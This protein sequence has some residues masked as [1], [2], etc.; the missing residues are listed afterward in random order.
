MSKNSLAWLLLIILALIWGCSFILIKEALIIFAPDELGAMRIAFTSIFLLLVGFKKLKDIRLQKAHLYI[1]AGL[2]GNLIPSFLF[3]FAQTRLESS[4]AGVLN[5][6]SPLFS[7]LIGWGIFKQKMLKLQALGIFLS[8]IGATCLSVAASGGLGSFNVYALLVVLATFCYGMNI[9]F[10]KHKIKS[11]D[12]I[13]VSVASILLVSPLAWCYLL[14]TDVWQQM[15]GSPQLLVSL[16]A[17]VLLAVF[18]SGLALILFN[19]LL[20]LTNPVFA[21][22]VTYLMP[23][24]SISIGVYVGEPFDLLHFGSVLLIA[25]GVYVVQKSSPLSQKPLTDKDA[26]K[27]GLVD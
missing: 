25:I 26:E 1:V 16:G 14:F 27:L 17:V 6:L 21:S 4:V 11:D 3:A 12:P 7:L 22:M 18:S 20:K 24:V 9:N 13:L 23:V 5:A 2:C 8:F 10:I 19:I 15:D